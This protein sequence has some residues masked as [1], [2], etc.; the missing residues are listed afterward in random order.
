MKATKL[1]LNSRISDQNI[2][3]TFSLF[4]QLAR[5]YDNV[6]HFLSTAINP[7][8]DVVSKWNRFV[9]EIFGTAQRKLH[10]T[11]RLVIRRLWRAEA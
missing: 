11:A 7:K 3:I 9:S 2:S 1:L 4:A 6:Y 5:L 8:N 10:A